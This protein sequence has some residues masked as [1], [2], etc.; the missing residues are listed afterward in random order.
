VQKVFSLYIS[1]NFAHPQSLNN[2]FACAKFWRFF[3]IKICSDGL[4]I[5]LE[6]KSTYVLLLQL[7]HQSEMYNNAKPNNAN[8]DVNVVC[9]TDVG[10]IFQRTPRNFWL[11]QMR[12]HS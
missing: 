12:S 11:A 7:L 2:I 5:Y 3:K 6:L 9:R 1:I 10:R 8:N 4:L